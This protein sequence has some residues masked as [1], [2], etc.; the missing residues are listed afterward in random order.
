MK[1]ILAYALVIGAIIIVIFSRNCADR[2]SQNEIIG[3]KNF[4]PTSEGGG[5]E[6]QNQFEKILEM[7][8]KN[9]WKPT[10]DELKEMNAAE[11]TLYGKVVDLDNNPVA[12]AEVHCVPN[13]DPWIS[14]GRA[15]NLKTKSDGTFY[16]REKNSPM[17]TVK[18][19]APGYY[20]TDKS[21]QSFGFLVFPASTPK[22]LRNFKYPNSKTSKESPA[23]F[24]LR[25]MSSREPLIHRDEFV[26]LKDNDKLTVKIG[27]HELHTITVAF[28]F[29]PESKRKHSLGGF[30]MYHWGVEFSVDGG[31]GAIIAT[32]KPNTEEPASFVAPESG[33]LPKLRF[34][35]DGNVSEDAYERRVQTYAYVKFRDGTF[36]RLKLTVDPDVRRSSY[37]IESWFNPSGSRA[38]E[39]DPT[40]YIR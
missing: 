14:N 2:T 28:W 3:R 1:K 16:V 6:T 13:Y 38:T 18:V 20:S 29:N 39:P 31:E 8:K 17:L 15:I 21:T 4:A 32:V 25:K 12:G 34:E 40:L 37:T 7:E 5:N 24:Y 35:Y 26:F 27:Q 19:R 33:Y 10:E 23:I 9:D 36:A 30:P 11:A 22:A